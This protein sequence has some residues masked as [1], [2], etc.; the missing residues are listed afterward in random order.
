MSK[1][2][3]RNYNI[4]NDLRRYL[5]GIRLHP[6]VG[7]MLINGWRYLVSRYPNCTKTRWE[8]ARSAVPILQRAGLI[9]LVDPSIKVPDW[10]FEREIKLV[11]RGKM[12]PIWMLTH[13]FIRAYSTSVEVW[14]TDLVAEIR[15]GEIVWVKAKG[16]R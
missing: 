1:A 8:F 14:M 9:E 2:K 10:L 12:K 11:R 13:T 6:S 7:Y 4:E 5:D 16:P 15:D 3:K